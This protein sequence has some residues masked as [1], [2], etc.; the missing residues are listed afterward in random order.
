MAVAQDGNSNVFP[1]AFT[2]VEGET[3]VGWSFFLK[4]LKTHVASQLG[5]YLISDRQASIVS[6]YP[7]NGWHDPPST[8]VFCI[9]HIVQNFTREIKDRALRKLVMNAGYA[10][11]QLSFKHYRRE[12][13]LSNPDAGTW[14]DNILVEKWT[15]SYDNGQRWGHMT[16]NIFELMNDVF[17][18]IQNLP[19]TA[20]VKSTYFKMASLFAQRGERWDAMLRSEQLWSECCTRFIKAEGAKANTHV[21]TRFDRHNQNFMVKE[22][23][24]HNVGLPRQE[25]WVILEERWCDCRKFQAFCMPCSHVIAACAHSHIDAL[26]LL[27][28]IYMSETLLYIYN[29]DFVVVAKE[30]DWPVYEGEIVWHYDQMQRNKKGRLQSKRIIT[31]MDELDKLERKYGLC[32]QVRHNKKN[33]P[34]RASGSTN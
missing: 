17:K 23:I 25:Y 24:D 4:N 33:C 31:E 11:A 26:T 2:L 29:T 14:I 12:I 7:T 19:I 6:A 22:I 3:G 13:K 16:T 18:G 1:F 30:D 5:L 21:V 8:H 32:R 15:W 20:L 9:R 27:S 28:P 10:L 34:T